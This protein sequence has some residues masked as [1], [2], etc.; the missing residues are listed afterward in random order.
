[1]VTT[2]KPP[3]TTGIDGLA[4]QVANALT[5]QMVT[6][7]IAV[8][9]LA[10]VRR[11]DVEGHAHLGRFWRAVALRHG[12]RKASEASGISRYHLLLVIADMESNMWVWRTI[13]LN[14]Y[15]AELLDEAAATKIAKQVRR[16]DA[17]PD[18]AAEFNAKKNGA[19][20]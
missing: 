9:I 3:K 11:D 18:A 5:D 15:R 14:M 12:L 4:E 19:P 2:D 7:E 1:M 20:R 6:T 13:S 17:E 8:K 10:A 16:E